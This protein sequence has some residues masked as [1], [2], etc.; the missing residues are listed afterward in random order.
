MIKILNYIEDFWNRRIR[1]QNRNDTE[2]FWCEIVSENAKVFN[3]LY[4][5][6]MEVSLGV[7]KRP[8]RIIDEWCQRASVQWGKPAEELHQKAGKSN[9]EMRKCAKMLLDAA[10]QAGIT[11]DSEKI[12]VLRENQEYAYIEWH[13]QELD[14]GHKIE[15]IMPAWYQNGHGLEQGRCKKIWKP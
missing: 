2:Q 11:Y 12:F 8:D 6:I 15:V 14:A 5:G 10:R 13:M 7:S 3:G 4:T 9:K 1:K